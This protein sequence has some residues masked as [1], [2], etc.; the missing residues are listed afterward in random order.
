MSEEEAIILIEKLIERVKGK[1]KALS[2]MMTV[3]PKSSQSRTS[4]YATY[5]TAAQELRTAYDEVLQA[6]MGK[7]PT[8]KEIEHSD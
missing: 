2:D 4:S 3:N 7:Q 5:S 8:A 6:M 1:E